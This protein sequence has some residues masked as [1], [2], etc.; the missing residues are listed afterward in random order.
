[1]GLELIIFFVLLILAIF[2]W[3]GYQKKK[4]MADEGRPD[5][6]LNKSSKPANETDRRKDRRGER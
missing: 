3:I 2:I 6:N 5:E 1:M 4:K